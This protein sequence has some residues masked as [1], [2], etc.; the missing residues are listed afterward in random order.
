MSM[1]PDLHLE[2]YYV[3]VPKDSNT[4]YSVF[5]A[6]YMHNLVSVV[7]SV[8]PLP[9]TETLSTPP[10]PLPCLILYNW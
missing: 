10:P 6:M 4:E 3:A 2:T 8:A 1:H 9:L 5:F 7:I